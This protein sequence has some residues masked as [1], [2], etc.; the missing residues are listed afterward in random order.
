MEEKKE[1]KTV[2]DLVKALE[3]IIAIPEN[4]HI[5]AVF[6][7]NDSDVIEGYVVVEYGNEGEYPVMG[8]E[9]MVAE[10]GRRDKS[11]EE[12]RRENCGCC[13]TQRCT[14]EGEWLY[15]CERFR[16]VMCLG[17]FIKS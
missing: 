6:K 12:F 16:E 2:E 4:H 17:K 14:G 11:L 9:E 1:I 10:Y 13:G 15:G 3:S 7:D 5:V 8:I